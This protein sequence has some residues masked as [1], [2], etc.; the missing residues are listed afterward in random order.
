MSSESHD[1]P[2][3]QSLLSD[4]EPPGARP[5]AA[6]DETPGV[7][8]RARNMRDALSGVSR[9]PAPGRGRRGPKGTPPTPTAPPAP[10]PFA[11]LA[12]DDDSELEGVA[13]IISRQHR[14]TS[15]TLSSLKDN[16]S[17]ITEDI[18]SLVTAVREMADSNRNSTA[19]MSEALTT[20]GQNTQARFDANE[21]D[22]GTAYLKLQTQL[23]TS[24]RSVGDDILHDITA[25]L[26]GRSVRPAADDATPVGHDDATPVGHGGQDASTPPLGRTPSGAGATVPSDG[27]ALTSHPPHT[28]TDDDSDPARV[29]PPTPPHGVREG[30]TGQ[31]SVLENTRNYFSDPARGVPTTRH[32]HYPYR[33]P[34]YRPALGDPLRRPPQSTLDSHGF[35]PAPPPVS[36]QHY[37]FGDDD[38]DD[39]GKG[40]RIDSPRHVDRR[41]SA[42]KAKKCPL[43]IA[44]LGNSAYHGGDDGYEKL[45]ESIVHACGYDSCILNTDVLQSY[46]EIILLHKDT[47]RLWVNLRANT[48]GPQLDR[49]IEKGLTT[50][51]RLAATDV[52]SII[53]FYDKLHQTSQL[54][55]LPII[56]FDCINLAMGYE[57]LCPPGL[58]LSKYARIGKVLLEVVPR[59]L[60]KLNT[61]LMTLV[62]MVRIESGNGYDLLWRLLELGVPGFDPAIPIRIPVWGSD[63][64]FEFANS[65]MLYY[66]LQAK[67]GIYHDD[68]TRSITFLN[69]IHSP[70]YADAAA[71]ILLN[72]H[73]YY[74]TELDGYLPGHLCIMGIASQLHETT[75]TRR[76]SVIPSA[77]RTTFLGRDVLPSFDRDGPAFDRDSPGHAALHNDAPWYARDDPGAMVQGT[78]RAARTDGAPRWAERNGDRAAGGGNARF[79]GGAIDRRDRSDQRRGYGERRPPPGRQ[80]RSTGD[81]TIRPDRNRSAFLPNTI[82][83][84]CRRTGHVAATC[85][86][87]AMALLLEKYKRDMDDE[88]KDRLESAWIQRWQ[89]TLGSDKRPRRVLRTYV[90]LL[91]ITVDDLDEAICWECWP[92]DDDADANASDDVASA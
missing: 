19:T 54:Y 45:T 79:G 69:G 15:A 5:P 50:F 4:D 28:V 39:S 82:C 30:P 20:L 58:G 29:P 56:P 12:D 64:I 23:T 16:I 76:A 1:D 11:E 32:A 87:L 46:G 31:E 57:A 43:D 40:G 74:S 52:V 81:R 88:S 91:D 36:T 22:F 60:P 27:P 10:N 34:A 35:S 84:A 6:P 44:A 73:N 59:L 17:T 78:P 66:R 90:D 26:D 72:V 80:S 63:D 67:K 21:K 83:E 68:R 49:I 77:R 8:T 75:T 7:H 62:T 25:V 89:G 42:L 53:D 14:A 2:P 86:V 71:T 92:D 33:P 65:F 9:T 48:A 24:L 51:P 47:R 41:R 55:L 18:R 3:S 13:G 37:D 85:D 70:A 38:F 61:K